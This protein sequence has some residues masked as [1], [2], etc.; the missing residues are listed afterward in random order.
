MRSPPYVELMALS[1]RMPVKSRRVKHDLA[2]L[3]KQ[4]PLKPRDVVSSM[5][6]DFM[7]MRVSHDVGPNTC[8]MPEIKITSAMKCHHASMK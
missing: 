2:R 5:G 8:C 7:V 4:K 1:P 3:F 6:Y